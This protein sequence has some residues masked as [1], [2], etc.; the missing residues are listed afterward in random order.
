MSGERERPLIV[1]MGEVMIRLSTPA[2]TPLALASSLDLAVAGTELNALITARALGAR[3]RF[4]TRLPGSEFGEMMRRHVLANQVELVAKSDDSSR[5]GLFFLEGGAPP[6]AT[7]VLYDRQ[8]SAATKISRGEFDWDAALAGATFA[9]VSGITCALGAEPLGAVVAFLARARDL[10]VRTSFDVNYRSRLWAREE[11]RS[12]LFSVL[13]LVDTIFVA[14]GDFE[15]L[16]QRDGEVEAFV[17]RLRGD[18]GVARVVVRERRDLSLD[19][20]GVRVRA[21]AADVV[22][23]EAEGVVVDELGA[24]DAAAGAFLAALAT[25]EKE[26][27]AVERCA[28][29]YARMLTI[30]GDAW[31]G[32]VEDL[33][34][35]YVHV[36]TVRR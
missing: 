30:P 4:L 2:K 9:H 10:G 12:S 18:F 34:A 22:E 5:A 3:A 11:A 14:P 21:F 23:A 16:Y 6:R 17:D 8:D 24:G 33:D 32:S 27:A 36:R 7:R 19:Q 20:I 29:A 26:Q 35:E 25:G 1:A 28:R 15:L 31:T 13:G